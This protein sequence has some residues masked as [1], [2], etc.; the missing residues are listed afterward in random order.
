M[1]LY[2]PE[3]LKDVRQE[4]FDF[5]VKAAAELPFDFLVV[6]GVRTDAEQ[7]LLY[8]QGRTAPGKVVTHAKSASET[9]HGR[10]AAVDLCPLLDGHPDWSDLLRFKL[11]GE[12][13][14]SVGLAW[15]GRFI[16]FP[17]YGHCQISAWRDLPFTPTLHPEATP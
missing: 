10:G 17:D 8:A 9:A 14:E 1:S 15:G 2:H 5:C 4:L 12:L 3:R 6:S 7:R 13:A 16:G 11:L